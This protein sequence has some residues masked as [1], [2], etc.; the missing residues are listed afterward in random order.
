MKKKDKYNKIHREKSDMVILDPE[1]AW[2]DHEDEDV[3]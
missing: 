1:M 2:M 3:A